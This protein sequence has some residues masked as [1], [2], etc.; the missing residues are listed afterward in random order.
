MTL[1]EIGLPALDTRRVTSF[2]G[3]GMGNLIRMSLAAA[4][5]TAI[6]PERAVGVFD[7][8][9]ARHLLD[10]TS[11]YPTVR[12]TLDILMDRTLVVLSNKPRRHSETILR[13]LGIAD[14]FAFIHGGDSF[15]E[16]KPSP[17]PV[18]SV[19]EHTRVRAGDALM[20]GDSTYD[21]DAGKAASVRTGAALYG[22]HDRET[23]AGRNPDFLLETF[24]D[25]LGCL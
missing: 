3:R 7:R 24:A 14:R 25:L 4:G 15:P 5:G 6:D 8:I 23:L 17:L 18:L 20:V 19:L 16:M 1:T 2:I 9:Y 21:I 13:G 11:L 22:F 10:A 12:E